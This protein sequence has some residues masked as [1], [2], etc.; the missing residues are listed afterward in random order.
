MG[1]RSIPIPSVGSVDISRLQKTDRMNLP[2][3]ERLLALHQHF[4][5]LG[6]IDVPDR[7]ISEQ[8]DEEIDAILRDAAKAA[9]RI[10]EELNPN[11]NSS[12]DD[13]LNSRNDS[14]A[15]NMIVE[16]Y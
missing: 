8:S 13:D 4:V 16:D 5:R 12:L 3:R 10:K 15:P 14:S 7:D 6:L 2:D 11:A 1:D 9:A